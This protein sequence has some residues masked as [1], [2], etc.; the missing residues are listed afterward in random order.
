MSGSDGLVPVW[1]LRVSMH[2]VGLAFLLL[3]TEADNSEMAE[4]T[5][6]SS[7]VPFGKEHIGELLDTHQTVI[8]RSI[9]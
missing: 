4:V 5:E 8:S 9:C 7:W 1:E 6:G 2:P 3:T